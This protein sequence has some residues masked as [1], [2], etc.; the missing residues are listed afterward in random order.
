MWFKLFYWPALCVVP[1]F[2]SCQ[3]TQAKTF[4]YE[5]ERVKL[6]GVLCK[7]TAPGAPNY[8]SIEKGDRKNV[9][10]LLRLP[11]RI[12]VK[13]SNSDADVSTETGVRLVQ[14]ILSPRQYAAYQKLMN[15]SV[16]VRGQFLHAQTA[17][18]RTRV[19]LLVSAMKIS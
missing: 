1:A 17:H 4:A 13:S 11:K 2:A 6:S 15:K 18:H 3:T 16:V 19:M 7:V 9:V 14:L 12:N 10:W 5:P 8:E